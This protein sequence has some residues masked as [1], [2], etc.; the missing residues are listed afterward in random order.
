VEVEDLAPATSNVGSV[1]IYFGYAKQVTS[2]WTDHWFFEYSFKEGGKVDLGGQA[3]AQ[4][5][6]W[7]HAV[8][9]WD[10]TTNDYRY[11][12]RQTLFHPQ[13]GIGRLLTVEFTPQRVS[14]YWDKDIVTMNINHFLLHTTSVERLASKEP[15]TKDAPSLFDPLRGNLGL[16]CRKGSAVF[17]G[18]TIEPLA[19]DH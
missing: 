4:V 15:R 7:R 12:L 14:A 18:L 16:L 8:S 9:T 6:A 3:E 17:R 5:S 2:Q 10:V 11:Y 19:D 13:R 1:G